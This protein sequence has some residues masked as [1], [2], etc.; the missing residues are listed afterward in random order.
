MKFLT[1][2]NGDLQCRHLFPAMIV[3]N[4]VSPLS[5]CRVWQSKVLVSF[6]G[7]PPI[8]LNVF[9]QSG[10]WH[11]HF[12]TNYYH[13]RTFRACLSCLSRLFLERKHE[14]PLGNDRKCTVNKPCMTVQ[15]LKFIVSIHDFSMTV[16]FPKLINKIQQINPYRNRTPYI[17][18]PIK[19]LP[20][21]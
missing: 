8:V 12:K 10:I 2:E 3:S 4:L 21:F 1:M 5:F 16:R 9:V 17:K 6:F 11:N 13:E 20:S 15:L 18:H 14:G 19:I 7:E